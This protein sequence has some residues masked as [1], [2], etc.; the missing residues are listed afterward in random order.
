MNNI[1]LCGFMGCG[2]STVGKALAAATDNTFVDMDS[3]IEETA[4][5]TVS[6]IFATE[7]E[8]AFRTREHAA[9]VTLGQQDNL[10]IATGGGAVLRE[11]NVAALRNGGHIVWLTVTPETVLNR[12]KNDTTRPLLQRDDKETA[13]CE[14]MTARGPLYRAAADI[15]VDGNGTAEEI[16]KQI[17]QALSQA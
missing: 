5:M 16:A 8:A 15:I 11:D 12:L 3:Y 14:L 6:D 9:C 10:I 7:G 2:K 4:G 1:I 13:V 17:L